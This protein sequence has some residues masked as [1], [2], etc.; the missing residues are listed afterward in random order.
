[1]I[2]L[3]IRATE[4]KKEGKMEWR[5]AQ[6]GQSESLRGKEVGL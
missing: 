3:D 6:L 5:K 2:F 1:M 4:S